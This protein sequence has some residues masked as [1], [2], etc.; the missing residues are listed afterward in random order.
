M[1][2]NKSHTIEL[3]ELQEFVQKEYVTFASSTRE[4]KQLIITLKGIYAVLASGKTMYQGSQP[5]DAVK[6]YN[7]ITE[8]YIDPSKSFRI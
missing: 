3:S 6:A 1:K 2:K 5:S 4:R 8:K 7:A